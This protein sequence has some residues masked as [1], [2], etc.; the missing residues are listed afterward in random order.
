MDALT[1][2]VDLK[3][4]KSYASFGLRRSFWQIR[5]ALKERKNAER[6]MS[7]L[8]DLLQQNEQLIERKLG[9]PLKDL[10]ILEIGP[11]QGLE[12]A[13]YLGLS[14]DVEAMD[15]DVIPSGSDLGSYQQMIKVNGFGR[16][17]KTLG[18]RFLIGQANE[19]AWAKLIGT[20]QFTDPQMRYGDICTDTPP[21]EAY[22]LV[23]SWSVFEHL[24]NPR[25]A[26]A[27]IIQALKPGGVFFISLHLF[28][29]INGSHD[30]RAFTGQEDKL[31]LWGHL[32]SSTR[33]LIEPSS[34]LNQWRLSEWRKLFFEI[35]PDADEHLN[36]YEY[37]EKYSP[38]LTSDLRDQLKDYTDEELFTVDAIYIYRK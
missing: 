20:N 37:F 3:F 4:N 8:L 19:A 23:V 28:T 26:L 10:H 16:F 15:L 1:P 2:T 14:N 36:T 27:N 5:F 38:L 6:N 11:G 18:R 34:Y 32:R 35:A 9:K 7:I 29:S 13:R 25:Q 22:D 30:I 21:I 31:P 17:A 33:H 12:R 24:P